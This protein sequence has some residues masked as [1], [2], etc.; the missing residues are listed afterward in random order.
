[1]ALRDLKKVKLPDT[2]SSQFQNNV[3]E[4]AN[5]LTNNPISSGR[6]IEDIELTFGST[7]V[8]SHGLGRAIR[9]FMI[10]YKNNSVEVW[11]EDTNQTVPSKTIVLSTSAT[12]TISL[13]VF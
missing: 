6:L 8:V 13:Y 9:G 2:P 12:A 4:F 10:T 1:M 11:A 3:A 5:Q 7:T